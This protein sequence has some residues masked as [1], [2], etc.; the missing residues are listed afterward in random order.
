MLETQLLRKLRDVGDDHLDHPSCGLYLVGKIEKGFGSP[1][2]SW[3]WTGWGGGVE[4]ERDPPHTAT[5]NELGAFKQ[6]L[7]CGPASNDAFA[8]IWGLDRQGRQPWVTE[9]VVQTDM[10]GLTGRD[11]VIAHWLLNYQD[12]LLHGLRAVVVGPG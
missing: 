6:N 3:G 5:F 9:V 10:L 4:R 8:D 1:L 12:D 7:W 11:D 2:N